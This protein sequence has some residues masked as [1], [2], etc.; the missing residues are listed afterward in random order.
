MKNHKQLLA[1][2]YLALLAI[3]FQD[4]FRIKHQQLY[5]SVKEALSVELDEESEAIQRIFSNMAVEDKV[6]V[7]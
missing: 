3:P 7:S 1:D 5:A 6:N 2:F 4:K